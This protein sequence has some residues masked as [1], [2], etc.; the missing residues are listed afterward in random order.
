M[1]TDIVLVHDASAGEGAVVS[2]TVHVTDR[3]GIPVQATGVVDI[4]LVTDAAGPSAVLVFLYDTVLVQERLPSVGVSDVVSVSDSV[5]T[6]AVIAIG[7]ATCQVICFPC[8]NPLYEGNAVM[9]QATF[10]QFPP[11]SEGMPTDPGVV[12]LTFVAG[13]GAPSETWTYGGVGA[14]IRNDVGAYQA[15]LT[16]D[17]LPGNW[18]IGWEGGDPAASVG[19]AGFT[20]TPVPF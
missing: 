13:E 7:P 17:G 19:V 12:S 10:T 1:I 4:V 8:T 20:V 3:V 6:S 5:V 18:F 16:T 14:I 11:Q 15:L 2:D 9:T